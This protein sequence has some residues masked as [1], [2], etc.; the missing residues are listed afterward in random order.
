VYCALD[1]A[2]K[3]EMSNPGLIWASLNREKSDMKM[4]TRFLAALLAPLAMGGFFA[5][6]KLAHANSGALF[7]PIPSVGAELPS[8]VMA[9]G[10]LL[11]LARRRRKKIV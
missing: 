11:A 6:A 9:C 4:K 10:G 2:G 8:L 3:A 1:S 5:A 7:V